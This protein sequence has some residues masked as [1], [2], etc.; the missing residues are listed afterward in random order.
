MEANARSKANNNDATR[1]HDSPKLHLQG[2][3]IESGL[4]SQADRSQHD[5]E[6]EISKYAMVFIQSLCVVFATVE[7]W[8]E[9]L[10][11]SDQCLEDDHDVCY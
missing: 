11:N 9:V 10:R 2:L 5:Q 8:C 4:R 1:Y 7:T 3:N 6:C